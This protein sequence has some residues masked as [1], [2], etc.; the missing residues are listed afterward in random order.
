[1]RNPIGEVVSGDSAGAKGYLPDDCFQ[2]VQTERNTFIAKSAGPRRVVAFG[3]RR[4][5]RACKP[6]E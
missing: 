1:M 4:Q 5:Q 3:T 6:L 2:E